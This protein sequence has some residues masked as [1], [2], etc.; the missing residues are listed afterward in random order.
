M[1]LSSALDFVEPAARSATTV[2]G[3]TAGAAD[4]INGPDARTLCLAWIKKTMIFKI[5]MMAVMKKPVLKMA[6]NNSAL[7]AHKSPSGLCW[8]AP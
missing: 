4:A 5:A 6:G 2:M 3:T 7:E 1:R 8:P